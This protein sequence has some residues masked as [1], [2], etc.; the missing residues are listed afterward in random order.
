LP[1][2]NQAR[3]LRPKNRAMSAPNQVKNVHDLDQ[4]VAKRTKELQSAN[5]RLNKE[6]AERIQAQEALRL[7][8]ERFSKAF[9]A[10]PN[11]MAIQS[12]LN[13]KFLDANAAFLRLT[14][15][16][17]DE[18]IGQTARQLR[19][20]EEA[21]NERAML[22]MLGHEMSVRDLACRFRAKFGQ[23][24][25][26][27]LSVELIELDGQ[28][29]LL[30]IAQD[31]T[32][33]LKLENQLRQAQKLEAVGQLAAGV[34][35]DFNNILAVVQ[36]NAS[37]LLASIA[38]DSPDHRP[39]QNIYVAAQQASKMISQLLTFCREQA[40]ELRPIE[41]SEILA[42]ATDKMSRLLTPA[43]KL[44]VQAKPGLP[45]ISADAAMMENL[46]TALVSNAR[47]AMPNG[48]QLTIAAE[49]VAFRPAD[50][51]SN[52]RARAGEFVRLTVRD[53]GT[54][55]PPEI[56]PRIFEP[57]F[58]TK[59]PGQGSGLGLATAYGI[60][61]QHK[62]WLEVQSQENQGTSFHVFLPAR[63]DGESSQPSP[64]PKRT[65]A[66]ETILVVDDEPDL[67]DLVAQVL[68][69]DGYHVLSA[70]SAAEALDQWAKRSGDIHLLLT[71]VVMPDGFTGRK[72]A[73]QLQSEDPRLRVL[74]TSG[75]TAGQT[76]TELA[77][78]ESR[79]FLPK[80]YRPNTLLRVVRECLDYP[81]SSAHSAK[82][83]A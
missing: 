12:L 21:E 81:S 60:V 61:K 71:D 20:W 29:F 63:S 35:H 74:F 14:G 37:M 57:F 6:I 54:G 82:E 3:P 36:G 17:R 8:E 10:S 22:E 47:D 19:I 16:H 33:R 39:L 23:M 44:D 79:N 62:G 72:L 66:R 75:Y 78:V 43:M 31:I 30:A 15:Y 83:A 77:N 42:V 26:I 49:A 41:V 52:P 56:L 67:R 65:T 50:V 13:E 55:I 25:E 27:L 32:E 69:S 24:L 48:G 76:G 58:T 73:D 11:P 45:R 80:P 2:H 18:L 5:E 68:E 34:A 4:L 51:S 70:G 64:M 9:Q 59:E 46:L 7:S 40:V 1:N 53:T 38:Q 28:P